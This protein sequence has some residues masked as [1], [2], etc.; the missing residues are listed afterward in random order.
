MTKID[1]RDSVSAEKWLA[2]V[3]IINEEYD[4]VMKEAGQCLKDMKD[5]GE[6]TLVDEYY[7]FADRMLNSSQVIFEAISGIAN[8]VTNI[9]ESLGQM[10]SDAIDILKKTATK[11]LK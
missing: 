3:Q 2:E 4:K 5:F 8:D 10:S 11:I 1:I 9:L 6:G 7:N